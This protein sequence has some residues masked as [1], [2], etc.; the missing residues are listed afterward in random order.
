MKVAKSRTSA[1]GRFREARKES[2]N[3]W[4][5]VKSC[6]NGKAPTEVGALRDL[7]PG[8][9]QIG[10][11]RAGAYPAESSHR[12]TR[13]ARKSWDGEKSAAPGRNSLGA[14]CKVSERFKVRSPRTH[15]H[16]TLKP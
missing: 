10:R 5:N 7:F 16:E 2:R 12:A 9:A 6:G 13:H 14:S 3:G 1:L 11:K 4:Q 15:C 8:K